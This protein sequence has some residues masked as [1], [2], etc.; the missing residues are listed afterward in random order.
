MPIK[1]IVEIYN[2]FNKNY[3]YEFIAYES[4]NDINERY[5]DRI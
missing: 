1:E 5:K 4:V 2:F 3:P